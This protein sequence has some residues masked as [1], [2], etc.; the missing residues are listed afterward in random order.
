MSLPVYELLIN[1]NEGDNAEV[2]YVAL[3]DSPAIQ[4]DF[5]AFKENVKFQVV[6]ET[7][8]ILSGPMMIAE[9]LIYRNNEKFG[10][11]YVK[12]SPETIRSIAIKFAKKGF[13]KNVNIMHDA[14]MQVEG[15]TMFESFIVDKARGILPMKG[16]EDVADGS[17]FGSFYVENEDVW[18][19][20]KDGNL[21]GFSVEGMFDYVKPKM[22]AEMMIEKLSALLNQTF[23]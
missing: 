20:V 6:S 4:R 9:Q 23:E 5:V 3:V 7:E 10:E 17:W 22:T 13:Q 11:H 18:N 21:K 2:S 12:F 14:S 16:F 15:V 1:D 8:H 19:A